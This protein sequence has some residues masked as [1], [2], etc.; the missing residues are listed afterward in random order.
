MHTPTVV[1]NKP[2]AA[3]RRHLLRTESRTSD[4]RQYAVQLEHSRP[5]FDFATHGSSMIH[6]HAAIGLTFASPFFTTVIFTFVS[7]K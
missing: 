4:Y 7:F 2:A 1:T 3:P 6:G 5:Q